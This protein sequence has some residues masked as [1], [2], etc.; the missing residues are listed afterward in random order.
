MFSSTELYKKFVDDADF[1][2]RYQDFIF[3]ILWQKAQQP[4]MMARSSL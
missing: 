2:H 1:K 4:S 3:D